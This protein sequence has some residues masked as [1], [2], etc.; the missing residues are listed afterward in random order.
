MKQLSWPARDLPVSNSSHTSSRIHP[1]GTGLLERVRQHLRA[2]LPEYMV[3]AQLMALDAL[4]LSANGKLDRRALPEPDRPRVEY[5]APRTANEESLAAIWREVL[6]LERVGVTENFFELGG[7]SI[8]SLQVVARARRVGLTLTAMQLFEWQTLEGL[9]AVAQ[10]SLTA[11]EAAPMERDVSARTTLTP[12][13]VPLSGL[14]QAQID[15]L[16]VPAQEIEDIYPLSPMQQGM[17]FQTLHAPEAGHY[18][19]QLS[20]PVQGL[21]LDRFEAGVVSCHPAGTALCA[22][23]LCG[24]AISRRRC[25]L[26]T[27]ALPPSFEEIDWR[28][29]EVG[30][31]QLTE[32]AVAERTRGFNLTEAPLQRMTVVKLAGGSHHL[33]WT[34]HHLLLDGWS[35]ARQVEEALAHYLGETVGPVSGRYRAYIAWLAQQ[36]REASQ[37]FWLLQLRKLEE[38]TLLAVALNRGGIRPPGGQLEGGPRG[39]GALP[40]GCAGY[41]AADRVCT[42][43]TSDPEHRHSGSLGAAASALLRAAHGSLRSY[44]VAGR[45]ADLPGA[46]EMLGLFINTY[47]CPKSKA[48][49]DSR[50]LASGAPVAECCAARARARAAI[51]PAALGG[52][53][54]P[55]A[56]RYSRGV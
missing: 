31:S 33:I 42:P 20:V 47:P 53:C 45:P 12:A 40:A 26:C 19:N 46:Q 29:R 50:P 52:A 23:A 56:V 25:R 35:S 34:Q 37:R 5:I 10:Q 14:T 36:D 15:A 24:R 9:A 28:D 16:P 8:L 6:G 51:R 1:V 44:T 18:V 2:R 39:Q 27:N 54:R 4:P 48:R 49:A 38:P 17:L 30:E 21:E 13:D 22:R 11:P 3:P 43:R 41:R 55:G 7:D 32:L